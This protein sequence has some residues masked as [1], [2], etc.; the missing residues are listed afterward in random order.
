MK[1][2]QL[3]DLRRLVQAKSDA[4]QANLSKLQRQEAQ[5]QDS[6]S[7]LTSQQSHRALARSQDVDMAAVSGVDMRWEIW[8]EQRKKN[9]NQQL[10]RLRVDIEQ[11][12]FVAQKSFAQSQAA[13][14]LWQTV[15]R[16]DGRYQ[17]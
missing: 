14:E 7:N 2:A 4:D 5:L 15:K 10:A 13:Q 16:P 8:A 9:L 11:A 3:N 17:G 1:R 12:R 6:I